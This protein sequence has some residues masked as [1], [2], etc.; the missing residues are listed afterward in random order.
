MDSFSIY[1]LGRFIIDKDVILLA[2]N[3]FNS[4]TYHHSFKLSRLSPDGFCGEFV[5]I[6]NMKVPAKTFNAVCDENNILAARHY[7]MIRNRVCNDARLIKSRFGETFVEY[8]FCHGELRSD[9][10]EAKEYYTKK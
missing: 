7:S 9:S 2:I 1:G 8:P 3:E 6:S 10:E 5:K 4:F